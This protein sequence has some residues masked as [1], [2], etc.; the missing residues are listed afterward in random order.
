M[1]N[2][3]FIIHH[4]R[5]PTPNIKTRVDPTTFLDNEFIIHQMMNDEF[6]IRQMMNDEFTIHQMMNDEF[7]TNQMMNNEFTIHFSSFN[8]PPPHLIEG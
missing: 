7:I 5:T 3:L 8:I 1:M 4:S 6:T 2:S